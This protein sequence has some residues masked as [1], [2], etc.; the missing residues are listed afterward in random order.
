VFLAGL[1][2]MLMLDRLLPV[3][4]LLRGPYTWAGVPLVLTGIGLAVTAVLRL[5]REGTPVHPFEQPAALVTGG[6]F[7]I[8]R[9]PIYLGMVI[10][11]AGVALALGSLI[12]PV[13][14]PVFAHVIKRR[15]I[16]GE[17]RR[18]L[19]VFGERYREYQAR[20]RRWL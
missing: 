1:A 7:R 4:N 3:R 5:R 6:P 20:V 16:L 15:F 8:S 17:E 10:V 13:V 12:P 18:L 2:A 14:I 9:N 11:L 19:A